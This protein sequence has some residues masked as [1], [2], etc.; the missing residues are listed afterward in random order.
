MDEKATR[1]RSG[2]SVDS[3]RNQPMVFGPLNMPV[4]QG[5]EGGDK[6]ESLGLRGGKYEAKSPGVAY[7]VSTHRAGSRLQ[8]FCVMCLVS[9]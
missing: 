5:S 8:H 7:G 6:R 9:K 3:E 2:A 1:E 4:A